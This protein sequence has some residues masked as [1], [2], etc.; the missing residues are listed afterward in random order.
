MEI[1]SAILLNIQ[2]SGR[3][4]AMQEDEGRPVSQVM[5]LDIME[6]EVDV[7]EIAFQ[8]Q[9][10]YQHKARLNHPGGTAEDPVQ[11]QDARDG[12]RDVS[13]RSRKSVGNMPCFSW[14]RKML[15]SSVIRNMSHIS[16]DVGTI[17]RLL[18]AHHLAH[19]DAD[20]EDRYSAPED[21][22]MAY[23]LMDRG[24]VLYRMHHMII[25][26]GSHL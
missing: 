2:E 6:H 16:P 5:R 4:M 25:T 1:H 10:S 8:T 24:D 21:F 20:E 26:T 12:E 14:F 18:L 22:Q 17:K 9:C 13:M 7:D 15:A 3:V 11:E 23:S 19:V